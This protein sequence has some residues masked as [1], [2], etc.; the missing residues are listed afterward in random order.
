MERVNFKSSV[1]SSISC[2]F[3]FD[4]L[5]LEYFHGN[6]LISAVEKPQ[7]L[8]LTAN[9]CRESLLSLILKHQTN[10]DREQQCLRRDIS[11][12]A[13]KGIINHLYDTR[14]LKSHA[15]N[16][17]KWERQ[18][19]VLRCLPRWPQ[20]RFKH[21]AMYLVI[22]DNFVHEQVMKSGP[23]FPDDAKPKLGINILYSYVCHH[24]LSAMTG[25]HIL[26]FFL[27]RMLLR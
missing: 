3:Y 6:L 8:A 22:D 18:W 25:S 12:V 1:S 5:L 15:D 20:M 2:S 4:I 23:R 11:Y 24:L 13:W 21:F 27:N 10:P 14:F 16:K 17:E 9:R 26:D 7:M 19:R